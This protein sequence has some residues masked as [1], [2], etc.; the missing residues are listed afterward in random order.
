MGRRPGCAGQRMISPR[1]VVREGMAVMPVE[2]VGVLLLDEQRREVAPGE[3]GEIV[4]RSRYLSPGYWGD[5]A[6]TE[7]QVEREFVGDRHAHE[8]GG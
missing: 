2:G 5:V 6:L 4:V 7:I 1:W 3:N 8:H